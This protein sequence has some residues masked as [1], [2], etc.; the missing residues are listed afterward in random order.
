MIG[1]KI[2]LST[3]VGLGFIVAGILAQQY[4]G[5]KI[6]REKPNGL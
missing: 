1:E 4:V 6:S 5:R 3:I 2:L